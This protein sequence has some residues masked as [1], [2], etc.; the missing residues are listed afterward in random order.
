MANIDPCIGDIGSPF[1][2]RF[3]HNS[4]S[5]AATT[6]LIVGAGPAGLFAACEL[7]RHGVRP[8]VVEQRLAPH[9][10]ARG[11]ALQPA[12]LEMLERAGLIELFLRAGVRIRHIQLLGP[13][14]REIASEHFADSGCTYEFQCSLPQWRTEAILREHL[15][16]LGLK[17]EFGTEVTSIEDDPEGVRVTLNTGGRTETV[18]AAYV[19]GAGG[20]HSITRHSMQEHLTG[21]TYDG[22]Y[23]V[24][25]VKIRL[26]CPP[27]CGRLVVGP[28]GFVLFSPLPDER[29]LIFVNCDEADTRRELP[30][31]AELGALLNAKAG[32]DVGLNDLRWVSPFKMHRRVV[33]RL[34]DGRR[35]LLGDAAHLSSP[36]GGEGLNSSLMDAADIAWKLALV[37]RGTAKPSLLGS[38]AIERGLADRHVL[39]VSDQVHSLVMGLVAMC[40]GEGEPSVPQ[41]DDPTQKVAGVRRRLML[42]VSYAGSPLVGQ[43]GAVIAGPSPGER[44]PSCHRL[45]GTGHHL[46]VFGAA[47]RLDH[48]RARWN[49]LV[50]IGDAANA[51]FDATEAGVPDG[52]AILVRP[53]GFIGFRA[54]PVDETTMAALDDHL[55]T[56]LVPQ[57]GAS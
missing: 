33:E 21:E 15:E 19:L 27:E 44:F 24:A 3:R 47:P 39:E 54:A 45:R 42:D 55:A 23:F 22:R 16:S 34:G 49:K 37:L 12:V 40:H 18:T 56:Y 10:E 36:L 32:V 57:G 26:P 4:G 35:F 29:W 7:L 2:E 30:T 20:G 1:D 31:E 11:T 5:A 48:L 25:D 46:I 38:Y 9:R 14:L 51:H 8:R 41:G 52:G 50:S 53:D 17:V 28:A 6:V 13:G 43:A